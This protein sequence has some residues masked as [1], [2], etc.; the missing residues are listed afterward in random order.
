MVAD[1]CNAVNTH[2]S[3][4][5]HAV[6]ELRLEPLSLLAYIEIVVDPRL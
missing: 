6:S 2:A 1:V 4:M 5:G 3:P